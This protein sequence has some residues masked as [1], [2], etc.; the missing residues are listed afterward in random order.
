MRRCLTF[1]VVLL[2]FASFLPSASAQF[3]KLSTSAVITVV[4]GDYS[5]GT[6]VLRNDALLAYS[7]VSYQRFWVENDLGRKVSGFNLTLFPRVFSVWKGGEEKT[8]HYNITCSKDVAPGNYTLHLRFLGTSGSQV[9]IIN[10]QIPLR[11]LS[12]PLIFKKAETYVQGRGSF[13]YAFVGEKVVVYSHIVNIGHKNVTV[14]AGVTL[15]R[16]GKEYYSKRET[17]SVPPGDSIVKFTVPI[18]LDYPEGSYTLEYFLSGCG[19]KY[20]FTR[21]FTVLVGVK[22][23]GVSLQRDSVKLNQPNGLYVTMLSERRADVVLK[24]EV[25]RGGE[26]VFEEGKNVTVSPGVKVVELPL[27]TNVG[28]NLTAVVKLFLED[29]L[30]GAKNLSYRVVALPKITNV[31]EKFLD[32]RLSFR[33]RIFN[34]GDETKA[35][36][37][38]RVSENGRTLYEDS[39]AHEIPPGNSS[40]DLVFKVSPGNVSYTFSL[41]V[42]DYVSSV[43]GSVYIPLP[44]STTS[45]I[46]SSTISSSTIPSTTNSTAGSSSGDFLGIFVLVLVALGVAVGGW[47][48]RESRKPR[49]RRPRP[50]RRSPLGRFKRPKPPKFREEDSLPKK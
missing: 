11:V 9:V 12:S 31:T 45:T 5:S 22:L 21:N 17:I 1:L 15:K 7:V 38:Y 25:T 50:K 16:A 47:Y 3:G 19:K 40:V 8:L 10:V 43:N 34:P 24:L 42:S 36:L 37:S 39:I 35:I 48:Y 32:G 27:P 30:V 18:G 26:K 44:T 29:R 20:V 14:S 46:T 28:G 6:I 23:V 4:R 49:R 2:L 33:I 41:K 13:S